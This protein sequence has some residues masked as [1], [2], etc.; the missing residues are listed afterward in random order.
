MQLS[1]QT[2]CCAGLSL[3]GMQPPLA[4]L[5]SFYFTPADFVQLRAQGANQVAS[6]PYK[7]PLGL[8]GQG[9]GQDLLT[10]LP[11]TRIKRPANPA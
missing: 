2:S 10:I 8:T 4:T 11:L 7:P 9:Q 1:S 6:K 5:L 3:R